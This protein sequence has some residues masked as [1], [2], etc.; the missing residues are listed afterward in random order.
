MN[1]IFLVVGAQFLNALIALIDKRIVTDERIMPQPFVYAFYTCLISGGWV[2]I[3]LIN[4]LPI[5]LQDIGIPTFHNVMRPTLEVTALAFLS[6]YTFFTAL[7]SMFTALQ[8]HDAS[9]VM[10]VIGSVS[11]I[12]AYGLG[13]FFLD[14]QLAPNFL[15]GVGILAFGTVLVSRF[16]FS[17]STALMA[18][19]AGIFFAF[20]YIT[21]KGLFMVTSFDDGFFWSRVAFVFF[22]LTLL[23]IPAYFER[24]R[25]QTKATKAPAYIFILSSKVLAGVS[26]LLI[27]HATN[28]GDVAVVQALGGLQY[29]FIILFGIILTLWP[30]NSKKVE[31]YHPDHILQKAVFVAVIAIGF[32][33][34]F[35]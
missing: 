27:L 3:Y 23:M 11:A 26:T 15:L 33:V 9:D 19:Y 25:V 13:Y 35:R 20:H 30:S 6:A 16:R 18:I 31:A 12:A 32:L 24:V 4:L 2:A 28:L 10:P 7:T 21:L 22:A 8:K 34:L 14:V 1:W 5:P 29:V 17:L